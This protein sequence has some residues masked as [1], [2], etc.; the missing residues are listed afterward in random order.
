MECPPEFEPEELRSEELRSDELLPELEPERLGVERSLLGPAELFS[1]P[2]PGRLTV[3]RL[4]P[5]SE[6]L[7]RGVVTLLLEV[8]VSPRFTVPR[9]PEF[10]LVVVALGCVR[11]V[12]PCFGAETVSR[13]RWSVLP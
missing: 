12:V 2:E 1:E 5:E 13:R 6:L 10:L 8:D 9:R 11:F 7:P 4:L 3:D